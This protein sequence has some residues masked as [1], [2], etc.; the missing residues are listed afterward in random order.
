MLAISHKILEI[1]IGEAEAKS[2][3][4]PIFSKLQTDLHVTRIE[5]ASREDSLLF[6]DKSTLYV[7]QLWRHKANIPVAME[8]VETAVAPRNQMNPWDAGK[9][10]VCE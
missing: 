3:K 9:G 6:D 7:S 8:M 4:E 1:S 2:R 5:F 10:Y